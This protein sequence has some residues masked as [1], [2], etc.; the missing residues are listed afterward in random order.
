MFDKKLFM[1]FYIYNVFF[2]GTVMLAISVSEVTISE[3]E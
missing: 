3:S 1:I 2:Q